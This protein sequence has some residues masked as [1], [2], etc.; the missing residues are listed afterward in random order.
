MQNST[1]DK[2]NS[3]IYNSIK[4]RILI[5][6]IILN[7]IV[8]SLFAFSPI[9][10]WIED[11]LYFRFGNDWTRYI[12]FIF[13]IG[14]IFTIVGLI[15]DYYSNF[16]IEH[17]FELSNQNFL[18][19]SIENLKSIF[20]NTVLVFPFAILFF[21]LIRKTGENWWIIFASIVFIFSVLLAQLAPVLILPLFYKF[22]PL[23]NDEI[24]EKI[25]GLCSRFGINFSDIFSFNMSKNTKKANAGFTGLGKTKRIILSDT[26]INDFKPEEIEIIFAHELGHNKHKH[27]VKNLFM[28]FIIIFISFFICSKLFFLT[29]DSMSFDYTYSLRTVPVLFFYITL[30]SLFIMPITNSISRYFEKQADN[31]ALTATNNPKAFISGMEKLSKI[32]LSD[33]K[34]NPLIEFLFYSHPSIEKR[35]KAAKEYK[36][37]I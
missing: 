34:P 8:L 28:S 17:D 22:T 37:S 7:F 23:K 25:S 6:D 31:F 5:I 4:N 1:T 27:I 19:W 15:K 26:L 3:K 16:I 20:L 2:N 18:Q 30:F 36:V 32:N 12:I 9:T 33:K 21:Y 13:I 35:I 24:N 11:S 29:S 10:T 14:A